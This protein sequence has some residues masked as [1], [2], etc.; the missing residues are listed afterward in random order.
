M[1]K[2]PNA[3]ITGS[4]TEELLQLMG[5]TAFNKITVTDITK[6]AGVGRVSFY[7]NFDSKEDVLR[8]HLDKITDDFMEKIALWRPPGRLLCYAFLNHLLLYHHPHFLA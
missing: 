8:A 2:R 3:I 5:N 1:A 7:R 4:I 6:K